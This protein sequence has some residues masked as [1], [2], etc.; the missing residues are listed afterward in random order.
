MITK[1][2]F[3][4]S[5]RGVVGRGSLLAILALGAIACGGSG[6][7]GT[8]AGG[9]AVSA[10]SHAPTAN[11]AN[12]SGTFDKADTSD[13]T[14]VSLEVKSLVNNRLTFVLHWQV[15]GQAANFG[16][17]DP[18]TAPVSVVGQDLNANFKSGAC[19]LNLDFN[20]ARN[21]VAIAGSTI[22][23]MHNDCAAALRISP[24][25]TFESVYNLKGS[26]STG[27]GGPTGDLS[28]F[29]GTFDK[30]DTSDGTTVSLEVKSLV[31]NRLTFVLHWQ[32]EG[33]AANLGDTD[34]ITAPVSV[35]G[36][37]LNANFK[38]GACSLNLDFN[39]ARN[40]VAIAGSTIPTMHDDCAAALGISPL[41]T[42]ETVYNLKH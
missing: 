25:V 28:N 31:N 42:F 1:R 15:E 18:I 8:G 16:D 27:A 36:Q 13:G 30:A 2:F 40:S 33:Q 23:T 20:P 22:P 24:L 12:F 32:V 41:V 10:G 5:S 39:P 29:S 7:D 21:S 11:I 4:A 14:T 6:D 38:S 19:S 9:A 34:P 3:A 35:V 17:T 26:G 37:D